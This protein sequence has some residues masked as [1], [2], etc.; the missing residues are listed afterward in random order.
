MADQRT[1]LRENKEM[2]DVDSNVYRHPN[3]NI[4]SKTNVYKTIEDRN[5]T[6]KPPIGI[7][8][9]GRGSGAK[10]GATI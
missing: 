10:T 9:P 6:T 8:T 7:R 2:D 1:Q 4:D 3:S 5:M